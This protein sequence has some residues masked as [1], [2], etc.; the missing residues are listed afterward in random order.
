M[1]AI[2]LLSLAGAAHGLNAAAAKVDISPDIKK[3]KIY[4]AGY[5]ATGRRPADV[6]D[7]LHARIL[8]LS[9][10]GK[11]VAIVGLDLLGFYRN[12]TEDLRKLT[13]FT[14]ADKYLFVAA[15][16]QHA[17]PD[18]LG[19][20]GPL[21]G[22]SGVNIRYHREIKDKISAALREALTRLEPVTLEGSVRKID[23]TGICK[24]LRNPTVIDPD[25]GVARF[26][27]RGG[28]TVATV[29]NYSCHPEVLGKTNL[30]ITADFPGPLCEGVEEALGGTCVFLSGSIGGLLS[31]DSKRDDFFETHRIGSALA[32]LA[33]G[34]ARSPV[35]K[36]V[37]PGLSWRS[38]T[39]L[40]PV[41]NP[42][43]LAFLPALTFGH[44]LKEKSGRSISDWMAYVL[45]AR[46]VTGLLPAEKRPWVET[47][48]SLLDI[49]PLR[50]LGLPAEI[51]PEL[52]IGGYDG[53]YKFKWPLVDPKNPDPPD[54]SKAPKGPYLKERME[55]PLK[56]VVGLANDEIGYLVPEYDFKRRE[57]LTLLPRLPGHHYEET[58]S[59]GKSATG[60]IVD[61][62][63]RLLSR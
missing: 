23:P 62:A 10:G 22:V 59:I 49:G 39:L 12:D 5:G 3:Q 30:L 20:W 2:L 15:T 6:H 44:E 34:Q 27:G 25:L 7:P 37:K 11:T 31:P 57:N 21:P 53:R 14:S 29:V 16:H 52:V 40:V 9:E 33:V 42:R 61:A 35:V 54:L 47:E 58:N 41:E 51:F 60:L 32:A 55:R 24:D 56:F 19:L 46:H 48:V 63:K 38:E 13:G 28:K 36:E 45:A 8:V 18:T 26:V 43:Y 4:M 50:L 17:G 1:I